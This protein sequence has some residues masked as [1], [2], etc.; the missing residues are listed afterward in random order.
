MKTKITLFICMIIGVFYQTNAQIP[1][2]NPLGGEAIIERNSGPCVLEDQRRAIFDQ[3]AKNIERLKE[4]GKYITPNRQGNH[5]LFIWPV[6]QADGF[7]YNSIWAQT[8]FVDHDQA[9][10]NQIEDY[11]CGT[12][13]YDTTSGY[14]HQGY[15]IITWPFWWKQMDLDQGINL[16]AADGQIIAK[17]DGSFDRNCSFNSDPLNGIAIQHSDGSKSYYYHFKNGGITS[18]DVGDTV[19]AG[20]YLG[21]I[22]S[23]GS[24]TLPH[25]HF[26]VYDNADNLIDPSVGPCN[27]LNT[28]TWW[29]N[30][31]PYFNPGINAA[32]THSAA[33]QF[34]TCPETETTNESNQFNLGETVHYAIYLRDQR[35]NTGVDLKITRP[36]GTIQF[37]W[38]SVSYT[39]L[40]LPTTPYV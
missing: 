38:T 9:F 28:D 13:S 12:R 34:N 17:Q 2:T 7:E 11:E 39:H 23:S 16:A 31:L 6:G 19:V 18:K 35:A 21:V 27:T 33:P 5:P 15:D 29:E 14:N 25:L 20:E 8:N 3:V 24:S 4:E 22:G 36:D 1:D 30:P 32:L 37:E 40:T 10:P 26:E